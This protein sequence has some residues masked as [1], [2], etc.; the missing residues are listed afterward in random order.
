MAKRSWFQDFLNLPVQ[1]PWHLPVWK[2]LL[3][4]LPLSA[5][6]TKPHSVEAESLQ[7]REMGYSDKFINT[8]VNSRKSSTNRASYNSWQVFH[9][10][11]SNNGIEL[12]TVKV[13]DVLS[14]LQKGLHKGFNTN[15]YTEEAG[16]SYLT[17]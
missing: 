14:F 15:Q 8:M 13:G 12:L 10:W 17:H 9:S 6:V 1:E 2:D 4:H 7:L 5:R 11:C 3:Q 16:D